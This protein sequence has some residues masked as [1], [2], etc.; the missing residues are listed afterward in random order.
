MLVFVMET[1]GRA[2]RAHR[3]RAGLSQAELADRAAIGVRTLRN[4]EQDRVAAPRASSLR[5]VASALRLS[6]ADVDRLLA[7][8][9]NEDEPSIGVLGPL[10][11]WRGGTVV[12]VGSAM[13]RRLLGLLALQPGRLV[14]YEE[15]IEVLWEQDPPKSCRGL[16]QLYVGQLRTLLEPGRERRAPGAVVAHTAGGYRL[17]LDPG[18]LD[19][20]RFDELTGSGLRAWQQGDPG[21]ARD[22]LDQALA[23]W[24]GP[25]L[26]DL[27]ERLRHHPIAVAVSRRRVTAVLAYADLAD[28]PG[29]NERALTRL[30][31]LADE[32]PLHEGV[33]ARLGLALARAGE[34]AAALALFAQV[35]TRLADEL[36]IEPGAQLR[37]A[38]LR[39]VRQQVPGAPPAAPPPVRPAQLPADVAGFT[40]RAALLDA[41]DAVLR[42][43]GGP[44]IVVVSGTGGVGKTALAVHW[45]HRVRDELPDGQLYVDLRGFAAGPP[46]RPID[47]LT[48]FLRALGCG[49]DQEPVDTDQ[50]AALYRSLTAD[51]RMLVVL[52][53]ARDAQHV[54]SLLP[55]G[56]GCLT[57]VTSRDRLSGLVASNGARRLP[58]D[59][60]TDEEAGSLLEQLVGADRVAG[61]P[62]AA[63]ELVELCGHLPLALRIACANVTGRAGGLGAYAARLRSGDRLVALAVDGDEQTAVRATFDLSFAALAEPE[64][65]LFRLLG[66]LPGADTTPA[67]AAAMAG[68]TEDEAARS[69]D[70]LAGAHLVEER[71]A[72]RYGLHD[73]LRIYATELAAP[74][75]VR[76]LFDWYLF[77]ADAAA[78]LLY[79]HMLRLPLPSS[80]D[81]PAFHDHVEALRWLDAE[82]HNLIAAVHRA[83]ARGP[84]QVAWQ[85]AD[86]L[87]G[88]FWLRMYTVDWVAVAGSGLE[89]ARTDGDPRA[90]AACELSL[91][92]ARMRR[93]QY[94][95]AVEH[96][97]RAL[98]RAASTGWLEAQAAAVN[99]LGIVCWQSGRLP[100]AV[101]HLTRALALNRRTG[102]VHGEA[103]N[104]GNLA[105]IHRELGALRVS[106]AHVTAAMAIARR[107][108]YQVG[109][110]NGHTQLGKLAHDL[111]RF[112]TALEQLA[113]AVRLNRELG[114]R[115]G[116]ADA[117]CTLAKVHRDAG[118]A[119]QVHALATETVAL[120]AETADR[121]V[122]AG[123][124]NTLA[125]ICLRLGRR[126]EATEH[127]LGALHLAVATGNRYPE[128][129]ALIGLADCRRGREAVEYASQAL[130]LSRQGGYRVLE[131]RALTSLAAAHLALPRPHRA[132][133]EAWLAAAIQR[134]TGHLLEEAYASRLLSHAYRATGSPGAA[135]T[136]MRR[137]I[138][139]FR[140]IGVPAPED[141]RRRG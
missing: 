39:V 33:A 61:E 77:T 46:V 51:K 28:E 122:E 62:D 96:A 129:E 64:R 85:L 24:R 105:I 56:T 27:G 67:A 16:I 9:G 114:N 13:L 45:A 75:G 73:L 44:R 54:R 69:L 117:L 34:Q 11:V 90:E 128:I 92:N 50:A 68:G 124:R 104:L 99:T 43:T 26:A 60:L 110:A 8:V 57:L 101:A 53:N 17:R 49:R 37:A 41:L 113:T 106:V 120:A 21:T 47:A 93:S 119:R 22:L 83:A 6:D 38:H 138:A 123:A 116:E 98:A 82:R 87:H 1:L 89:A 29:H 134:T 7:L 70:R 102:Q 94:R 81:A 95:Q 78:R 103:A 58:V 107:I 23:C 72:G 112:G 55:G 125:T 137:A 31:A 3:M 121:Q 15:I 133:R 42:E 130:D 25:L 141:L 126:D 86:V 71:A 88:Y 59:V 140:R 108:S 115:G 74:E 52:D 136:A 118:G 12:E 84:R 2:L 100:D 10:T 80:P 132:L 18:R 66:L 32:E 4:L 5:R 35:R 91:A 76:P 139:L 111:G 127:F 30:R 131:G 135:D 97:D 20:T 63:A 14:P 36:G 65:R 79:P 109:E 40:G 48:G 19:L